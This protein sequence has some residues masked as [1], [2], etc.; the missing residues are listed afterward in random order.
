MA[1]LPMMIM[2]AL[3]E[4]S[5]LFNW[6]VVM[7]KEED[8]EKAEESAEES[9]E[10]AEEGG[11][12][13]GTPQFYLLSLRIGFMAAATEIKILSRIKEEEAIAVYAARS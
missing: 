4:N 5:E 1:S 6:Y 7:E 9:V 11:R 10:Q 12:I 8:E 3:I 13:Y 2:M